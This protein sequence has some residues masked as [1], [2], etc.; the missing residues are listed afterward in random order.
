MA[1]PSNRLTIGLVIS[2]ALVQ[3]GYAQSLF[4]V[5]GKVRDA[6]TGEPM[7]GAGVFA[8]GK[9]VGAYTDE[10]GNYVITV[11]ADTLTI[12]FS[13]TGYEPATH[14]VDVTE[15]MK[16]DAKLR[17]QGT[18]LKDVVIE[19]NSLQEKL[20]STQMSSEKLTILEAKKL[21]A[22]FGEVDIIKTLQ[23]KPG[24]QS[25][26]EGISGMYVRGGG[27]D[28][29]LFLLDN[30][31][32]YNPSHLFGLFSTF[33]GDA[34]KDVTLY[35][36][37]FPAQFGGKLS[38]VIDVTQRDG[39]MRK[40]SGS[41]GIGV[42]SSRLSLEVPI[43]RDRVSLLVCGRRTYF[44]IF[45]RQLNILK[46]DDPEFNPIP[47]YYFYDFNSKLTIK[48]SPRDQIQ[49]GLYGGRDKFR[50]RSGDFDF[51]LGWGN[52]AGVADWSHAFSSRLLLKT[53]MSVSQYDYAFDNTFSQFQFKLSSGI[54]DVAGN[55]QLLVKGGDRHQIKAGLA[56]IYHA[57]SVGRFR[58]SS[59]DG[60][61]DFKSGQDFF[62]TEL[63]A[64]VNDEFTVSPKLTVN[65][66][67]RASGFL[68]ATKFYKGIEPRASLKYSISD[69][70]SIKA[71]YARMF[72][73]IH[74][75]ST[76]GASL[77]TDMWYPS[78]KI[79]QPQRSDQIAAGGS[80]LIGRNFLLTDEVYYKWIARQIDLRDG[81]QIFL[82]PELDQEFIFGKGWSYGNE[83]YFEKRRGQG[84]SL[85]DRISGWVGYTLAWNWRQF[86]AI[87]GGQKFHPRYDRRNDLSVVVMGDL[88]RRFSL[89][90]TFVYGTG[91]AVTLPVGL[92]IPVDPVRGIG[93]S[94]VPIYTSRNAF[95]MPSYHRMDIGLVYSLRP[96]WGESDL[97]LSIY[98]A[99]SRRNAYFLYLDVAT[100]QDGTTGAEI[101]TGIKIKQVSLFPIIPSLTW[102]FKF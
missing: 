21:P 35:K 19:A 18:T 34:V 32:V 68:G 20:N 56:Y 7:A 98:N 8:P 4:T 66:G 26:G 6:E 53:W 100:R 5:S 17:E 102:N 64:Y 101:P 86:D 70:V 93:T 9:R 78:G 96:K 67:V 15:N 23:L 58:A 31:P 46:K 12:V 72:Q 40:F 44:D 2:L 74:M 38:S 50:F 63:G 16:V 87:N 47:D 85:L 41:G 48:P 71:A 57:F 92:M 36:G 82:N 94:V 30:A 65:G 76:S 1:F 24:V 33:N 39:N 81:A 97:T 84:N 43:I 49:V 54:K 51:R 59:E 27:P 52:V 37:G 80:F 14:V 83:L 13:F 91:N 90:T 29:N 25:G 60:S 77:P 79:V 10:D 88:G 42:I 95:R 28:Q 89:S 61:I 55:S 62:G 69:K 45:T 75:V 22:L 3:I 73:Y 11:P 99:Y